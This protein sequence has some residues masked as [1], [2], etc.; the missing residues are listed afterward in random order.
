MFL[1]AATSNMHQQ[2][3]D[4]EITKKWKKKSACWKYREKYKSGR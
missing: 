2:R 3:L 1:V 4:N